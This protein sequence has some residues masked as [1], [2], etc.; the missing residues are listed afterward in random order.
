[1]K[2]P[3]RTFFQEISLLNLA[4]E[5]VPGGGG[6][7]SHQKEGARGLIPECHTEFTPKIKDAPQALDKQASNTCIEGF[8]LKHTFIF[9]ALKT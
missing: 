6:C 2:D 3:E 5:G 1:M 9:L 4:E 8:K 7:F